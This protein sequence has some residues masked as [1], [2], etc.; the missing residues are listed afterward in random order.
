MKSI[1]V[2]GIWDTKK[3]TFVTEK[4]NNHRVRLFLDEQSAQIATYERFGAEA[5]KEGRVQ[6]R[7][8]TAVSYKDKPE[9]R[10]GGTFY[11][12]NRVHTG[13]EASGSEEN[14][15]LALEGGESLRKKKRK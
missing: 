15:I 9:V 14:S 10:D 13:R 5:I 1:Q 6:L 4:G 11:G 7:T 3:E 8:L 12:S 2:F